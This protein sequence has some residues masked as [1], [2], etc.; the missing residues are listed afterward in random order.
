MAS[1]GCERNREKQNSE[2]CIE[3]DVKWMTGWGRVC[4]VSAHANMKKSANDE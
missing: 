1:N 2:K 3:R 4:E